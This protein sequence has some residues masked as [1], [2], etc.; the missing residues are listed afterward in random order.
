MAVIVHQNQEHSKTLTNYT[1]S[2][3]INLG[4]TKLVLLGTPQMLTRVPEG[5]GVTL[6]G[7]EMLPSCCAKD[8]GVISRLS[9]DEQVTEVVSK[10]SVSLCQINR[11]KHLFDRKQ[12][13]S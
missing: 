8:L 2:L 11:V 5:F 13:D 10:C 4:K 12:L 7:K 6:L 9:F 1:H 3:L